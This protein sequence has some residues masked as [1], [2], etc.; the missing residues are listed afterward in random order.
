MNRKKT[1]IRVQKQSN[2]VI[3]SRYPLEDERLSWEAR[4]LYSFL[5][6]KPDN[7]TIS[8]TNLKNSSPS[9]LDK[10][11]RILKELINFKYVEK[12]DVRN[13]NGQFSYPEYTIYELPYD[14]YFTV[15][16][17][18]SPVTPH[19]EHPK[20]DQ[21]SPSKPSLLKIQSQPSKQIIN[22]TTTTINALVWPENLSDLHKAS[23]ATLIANLDKNSSQLLIDELAGQLENIK[24]PVGY[25]RS[26]LNN[27]LSDTFIPAQAIGIQQNRALKE[28]NKFAV[29]QSNKLADEVAKR[30]LKTYLEEQK[31][32]SRK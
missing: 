9:G 3:V 5:L 24:N 22:K 28:K 21:P 14:G 13:E 27:Y 4:G 11:K 1:I 10:A 12:H 29:E 31:K 20:E 25:F 26:L 6:A 8:L 32:C 30:R 2:F 7:W 15:G 18:P 23:I 16:E 19:T 17:N